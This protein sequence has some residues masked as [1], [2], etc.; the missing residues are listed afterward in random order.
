MPPD[1]LPKDFNWRQLFFD[2][3]LL[4]VETLIQ[5][6]HSVTWL[7]KTDKDR[8]LRAPP[9]VI[10]HVIKQPSLYFAFVGKAS[11]VKAQLTFIFMIRICTFFFASHS[12][13]SDFY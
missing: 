9:H 1:P 6:P 2:Q 8:I 5:R 12:R 13:E 7:E 11:L 3:P 10:Q 4:A